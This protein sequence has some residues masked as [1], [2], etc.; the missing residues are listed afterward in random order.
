MTLMLHDLL[1]FSLAGVI[2]MHTLSRMFCLV[3]VRISVS[4]SGISVLPQGLHQICPF[5]CLFF[6]S[7]Y[8]RHQESEGMTDVGTRDGGRVASL[9]KMLGNRN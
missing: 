6:G 4:V 3:V 9:D 8:L 5:L 1:D 7:A 2:H